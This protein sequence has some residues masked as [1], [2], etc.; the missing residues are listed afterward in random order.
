VTERTHGKEAAD[1]AVDVSDVLFGRTGAVD[2]ELYPS[3][4]EASGAVSI[5][6]PRLGGGAAVVLVEAGLFG[7]K[8]EVRR[9]AAGGGLTINGERVTDVDAPITPI[10]GQWID[11]AIGKRRRQVLRAG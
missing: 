9:L 7:S 8:G 5:A 3:L 10:A 2:P 4:H 6:M 1:R 11:V